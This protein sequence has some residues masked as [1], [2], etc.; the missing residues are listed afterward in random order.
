[1]SIKQGLLF[2]GLA[3]AI[4]LA[5]VIGW[6][7][8][9]DALAVIIGVILGIAASVPTTLLIMFILTRQQNRLNQQAYHAPQHP[10]VIVVNAADAPQNRPHPLALP[11]PHPANGARQW[12]VIGDME[13]EE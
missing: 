8:S 11:P 7:V 6:R 12:T 1:M 13:T 10:P 4:T 3:F 9:T 2:I 5:V